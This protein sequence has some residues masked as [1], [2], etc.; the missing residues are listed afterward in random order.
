MTT[1]FH[2]RQKPPKLCYRAVE[3][4]AADPV[5][6]GR[7]LEGYAAVFNEPT[8][9][10]SFFGNFS[11]QIARGAFKR[12]LDAKKPVLQ[13]DHG[14]DPRTGSL[15]IGAIDTLKEDSTGLYVSARLFDN[16]LVEPIRQAIAGGA[17][18]GMSFRFRVMREEWR[19]ANGDLVPESDIVDLLSEAG[20]RGPLLRTIREV[21]LFELGPVVFPAY[22]AT[23]VGVR[24]LLAELDVDQRVALVHE[25]AEQVERTAVAAHHTGTVDTPWDGGANEKR[26]SSPMSLATA[27]KVYAWY[28]SGQV[29]GGQI[30]KSA[31]KFPHHEVSADGTPG[32]ANLPACRNGLARLPNA[33]IPDAERSAVQRHLQ[34]HLD[35]AERAAEHDNDETSTAGPAQRTPDVQAGPARSHPTY[36]REPATWYLPS[37]S[38]DY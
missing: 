13:F 34:A 21:E 15:P 28:D 26:L 37:P 24:S 2:V 29:D 7:T 36:L 20:E 4:R 32:A 11:E 18:T 3:F 22:D 12:T 33:G 8:T 23:S 6:D 38:T 17:I 35:D 31:C 14:R 1:T 10:E 16:D 5:T 30:T 9:I 27:K 19:D 25:L